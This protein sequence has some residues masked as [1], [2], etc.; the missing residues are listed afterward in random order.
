MTDA[1][2]DYIY[3]HHAGQDGVAGVPLNTRDIVRKLKEEVLSAAADYVSPSLYRY[4]L[5]D[6]DD[7]GE[8]EDGDLEEP[9][10]FG[11]GLCALLGG[12]S[13]LSSGLTFDEETNAKA[14]PLFIST[15][16]NLKA[17]S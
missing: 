1:G 5:G 17:A 3:D 7:A 10:I 12:G 11:N 14:K 16:A 9:V 8:D 15:V 4:I 13:R 2:W 6:E